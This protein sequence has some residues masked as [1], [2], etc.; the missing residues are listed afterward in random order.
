M[1]NDMKCR[2]AVPLEKPYKLYDGGGLHLWVSPTG[3][4]VWRFRYLVDGKEKLLSLGKFPDKGI[5]AAR[6]ERDRMRVS[7]LDGIDPSGARKVRK[8]LPPDTENSFEIVAREWHRRMSVQWQASHAVRLMQRLEKFVFPQIGAAQVASLKAPDV[9]A[10]LRKIE[11]R[12]TIETAHRVK[13]VCSQVMRY[14]VSTGRAEIDPTTAL[15]GALTPSRG[16]HLA[17]LTDP[18]DVAQLMRSINAYR[19]GFVTRI[20]LQLAP[21]VFLRQGELRQMKW[22]WVKLDAERPE[23]SIPAE[24]MKMSKEHRVPLARQSVALLREARLLSRGDYVFPSVRKR[25]KCMSSG[26]LN[27]ALKSLGYDGDLMTVHGFRAMARTILD[28]VLEY[29][30][31]VIEEQLSHV[32]QGSLGAAY[33]RTQHWPK[34]VEMMQA[35]ADYLDKLATPDVREDV[36]AACVSDA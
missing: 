5:R 35:W 24:F 15:R 9:L 29:D 21:L 22:A 16:K 14:A 11:A 2:N 18:L 33:N 6:E 32:K 4:K 1:L 27:A 36:L 31:D 7:L 3:V 23:V 26:T 12:G 10:V 8:G 20:A 19:G 13:D 30:W 34:R 17:A 25:D 28:E